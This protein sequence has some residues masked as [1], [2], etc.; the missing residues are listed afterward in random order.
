VIQ[1]TG[2]AENGHPPYDFHWSFGDG[3][4]SNLQNPTYSYLSEGNYTVVLSVTD[5][6]ALTVTDT[7][8]A[9]IS[10]PNSPPSTPEIQGPARGKP[11]VEYSY[12]IVATDPDLNGIFYF[13]DWGDNTTS[14]WLGPY[15]SGS[16]QMV[17]HNWSEKGSFSVRVKAKDTKNAESD[18]GTLKVKIPFPYE[19]PIFRFFTWLF[20]RFP[21]AFPILRYLFGYDEIGR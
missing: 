21:H 14:G 10:G 7:T 2:T 17:S 12:A 20:E 11:F 1:F 16:Q 13:V 9:L 4:S 19:L 5:A 6:D 3:G 18:W 8:W 15:P